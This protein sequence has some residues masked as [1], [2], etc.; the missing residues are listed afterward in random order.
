[1]ASR[2]TSSISSEK[3]LQFKGMKKASLFNN[4][5]RFKYIVKNKA[6]GYEIVCWDSST[7]EVLKLEFFW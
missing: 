3:K 2:Y 6:W 5:A 1:M 4:V 7:K